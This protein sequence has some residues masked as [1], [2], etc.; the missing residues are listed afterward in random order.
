MTTQRRYRSHAGEHVVWLNFRDSAH[1]LAGG[2]EVFMHAVARR[3][4]RE[5]QRVT[6]VTARPRGMKRTETV[7]GVTVRRMGSS[8]TVYLLAL[9][10]VLVHR[11]QINAIVDTCNGVPFFSPLAVGRQVPVVVLIHHVHQTMFAQHLPRPV[12][13]VARW[14]ER[15]GNRKVYGRRTVA[16]VSPSSRSEVRRVLGLA[17]PLYV[18]T[19][20][21]EP[22]EVAGVDRSVN[23]RIVVVGRLVPHKRW[24]LLVRAMPRVAEILPHVELHLVG[25]GPCRARLE[26]LVDEIG[27]RDRVW[28]HGR[29]PAEDRDRLLATS[30]LTVCTSEVEGWGLAVTEAMSLG[31]PAVVLAA[32]GL[33]DSVRNRV[34][35]WVVPDPGLLA[36]RLTDALIELDDPAAARDWAQRCRAWSARFA[37]NATADRMASLLMHEDCRRMKADRRAV[38][39]LATVVEMPIEQAILIDYR[40]LRS[41][42]QIDWEE[43]GSAPASVRLLLA[44]FDECDAAALLHRCGLDTSSITARVARPT[45][46]VGWKRTGGPRA[47][48]LQA[49]FQQY[50]AVTGMRRVS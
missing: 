19:N 45:D 33:R 13:S 31:I 27:L 26:A 8:Y 14:V 1:P 41:V 7:D 46:L 42:D 12:A 24:E 6:V 43:P 3:L 40:G 11:R 17:G 22:I 34:S 29:L 49:Y 15:V 23:P 44:G 25:D 20:G 36:A 30:W 37:W 2:A 4:V 47:Y 21:Q 18:A 38:C 32:P 28:L 48:D 50:A 39:D 9:L 5:G 16:V 35:G 10:W